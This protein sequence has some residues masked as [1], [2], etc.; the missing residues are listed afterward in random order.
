MQ[1]GYYYNETIKQ[2]VAI[3]GTLFN[4]MYISRSGKG[5]MR[6]PLAYGAKQKFLNRLSE[7]PILPDEHVAITLPRMSFEMEAPVYAAQY[8]KNRN[9]YQIQASS[10]DG[11]NVAS[12]VW[13][14]SPYLIPF[15]LNIMTRNLDEAH[16]IVEQI[17]PNF[18]PSLGL[19]IYPI[20]GNTDI[21]D[22]VNISL[23]TISKEDSYEGDMSERRL[24]IYTLLFEMRIN[25][26]G[27]VNQDINVI[28]KSIINFIDSDT[29]TTLMTRTD[30]VNP[31]SADEDDV[32]TIDTSY[33]FGYD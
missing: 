26:Y 22:D 32:Y 11:A 9:A 4:N 12:K 3:F 18:K 19:K 13:Q 1:G 6:V 30:A 23:Q 27:N 21:V 16:Q 28:K 2:A 20:K 7:R 31:Q 25:F 33:T 10:Q 15:E 8:Q 29:N 5:Q 24:I 14:P 17:L